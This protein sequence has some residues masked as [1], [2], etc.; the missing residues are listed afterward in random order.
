MVDVFV[1]SLVLWTQKH[2]N[3]QFLLLEYYQKIADAMPDGPPE[4]GRHKGL[5]GDE[6]RGCK[7]QSCLRTFGG[8]SF[9]IRVASGRFSKDQEETPEIIPSPQVARLLQSRELQNS[10]VGGGRGR[11]VNSAE[12][13]VDREAG[14]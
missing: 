14:A 10:A 7:K 5:E 12:G 9:E 4:C 8:T 11:S 6:K 13:G 2:R 3:K 1:K